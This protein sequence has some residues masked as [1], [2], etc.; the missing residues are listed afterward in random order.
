[1]ESNQTL[2]E[3]TLAAESGEILAVPA[4]QPKRRK[5][6]KNREEEIV[7][8]LIASIPLIGFLIF[9]L[10]PLVLA[11]AMAFMKMP[12]FSFTEGSWTGWENFKFVLTDR[13]FWQS[14]KNTVILGLATFISQFFA[15][16]IAYLLSKEIRGRKIW[17]MIY[18]IPYVCSVVAVTLMWRYMF[19]P[20]YGIINQ[21]LGNTDLENGAI[22]WL[23]DA[24]MF[25]V[26]VII[27]SV[28]SGM[29]YGILLYTAA[30]T[31]VN[32]SMIEAAR[33]DG[34]GPFTVFFRIVLP[35]ISPTTF[36]LLVMGV[37]GLLQSFATTNVLASDGGPNNNGVTIVFYMYRYIFQ[38]FDMGIASAAAWIL[39]VFIFAVSIFQFVISK[40]WVNYDG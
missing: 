4:P 24:N 3:E 35:T 30:L 36:Y 34:A 9:G 38:Y 31:N 14:V 12:G 15:L 1:M 11:F 5:G 2:F 33:I 21:M 19:N 18:F 32:Q 37:I 23:G 22:N 17:R 6:W 8:T 29:G 27:M 10:I 25:Y 13:L 26:T 28:W 16:G 7:G 40:R 39:A 20:G